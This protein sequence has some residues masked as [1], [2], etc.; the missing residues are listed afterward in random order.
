M[1]KEENEVVSPLVWDHIILDKLKELDNKWA[2]A[3]DFWFS[4][5]KE[6]YIID[7]VVE[8]NDSFSVAKRKFLKVLEKG[9]WKKSHC[10]SRCCSWRKS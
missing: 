4:L 1:M 6:G 2:Q 3:I 9:C 5:V 7:F 10:G 8:Y